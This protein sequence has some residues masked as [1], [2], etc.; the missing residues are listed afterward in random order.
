MK[1]IY[2]FLFLI[3]VFFLTLWCSPASFMLGWY[4]QFKDGYESGYE[5]IQDT[6][7]ERI[8]CDL[9]YDLWEYDYTEGIFDWWENPFWYQQGYEEG[10]K[11]GTKDYSNEIDF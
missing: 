4:P 1:R 10:V 6:L 9:R 3:A 5:D 8:D 11:R 2:L 7:Q